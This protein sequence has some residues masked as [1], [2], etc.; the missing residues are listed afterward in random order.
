MLYQLMRGKEVEPD[1]SEPPANHSTDFDIEENSSI[2][3]KHYLT[4]DS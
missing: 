4:W 3:S 1:A 2:N